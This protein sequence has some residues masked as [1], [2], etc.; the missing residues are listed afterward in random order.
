MLDS[1]ALGLL[2]TGV[3]SALAL[4]GF[5]TF[6][7]LLPGSSTTIASAATFAL[8]VVA[9]VAGVVVGTGTG[10]KDTAYWS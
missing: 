8:V 6:L 9:V 2:A 3:T 7:R 1:R 4:G 5:A 10:P